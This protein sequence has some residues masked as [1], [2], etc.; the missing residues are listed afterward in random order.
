MSKTN[1]TNGHLVPSAPGFWGRLWEQARAQAKE[2]LAEPSERSERPQEA[3]RATQEARRG[4]GGDHTCVIRLTSPVD[5]YYYIHSQDDRSPSKKVESAYKF[6]A[7]GA[8]ADWWA[9]KGKRFCGYY[10]AHMIRLSDGAVI[11]DLAE[12]IGPAPTNG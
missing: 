11:G 7:P 6:S 4:T 1:V 5:T 9:A 12:I 2:K 3:A 8:A 10:Y